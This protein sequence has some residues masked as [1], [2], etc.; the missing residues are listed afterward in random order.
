MLPSKDGTFRVDPAFAGNEQS[1]LVVRSALNNLELI[2]QMMFEEV[3][4]IF[5]T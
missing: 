3:M 1:N 5:K 4:A 2:E